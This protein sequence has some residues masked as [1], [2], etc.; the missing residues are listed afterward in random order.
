MGGRPTVTTVRLWNTIII[1]TTDYSATITTLKAALSV[2]MTIEFYRK[3]K[4]IKLKN[5]GLQI[6]VYKLFYFIKT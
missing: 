6:V 3:K 1:G 4:K 2:R 5:I